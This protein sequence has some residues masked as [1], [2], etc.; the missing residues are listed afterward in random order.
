MCDLGFIEDIFKGVGNAAG[1]VVGGIAEV[2]KEGTEY[3]AGKVVN[4]VKDVSGYTAAENKAKE[5]YQKAMAEV[6][7]TAKTRQDELDRLAAVREQQAA[8]QR[9]RMTALMQRQSAAEAGQR[10]QVSALQVKQNQYYDQLDKEQLA[11]TAIGSS[12]RVLAKQ[13]TGQAPTAQLSRRRR[14]R[15]SA[16]YRS[17]TSNLSVGSSG[18]DAGVGVNLGG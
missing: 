6:E 10:E 13:K 14:T 18:R 15:S 17:P 1:D 2:A 4:T 11:T 8:D 3:V 9:A 7:A 16:A 5:D 12:L